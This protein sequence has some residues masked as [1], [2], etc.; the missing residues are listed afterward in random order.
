MAEQK[1]WER[2]LRYE[3]YI[4]SLE[5]NKG[6]PSDHMLQ[7]LEAAGFAVAEG[8]P[9][10]PPDLKL[11]VESYQQAQAE[12]PTHW[13]GLNFSFPMGSTETDGTKAIDMVFAVMDTLAGQTFDPQLGRMVGRRQFEAVADS[14]RRSYAFQMGIAGAVDLGSGGP[15][16]NI[17]D[18]ENSFFSRHKSI[19]LAAFVIFLGILVFKS[20]FSNWLDKAMVAPPPV[21]GPV[22]EP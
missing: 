17:S 12:D 4:R 18:D 1:A 22:Q 8:L 7:V 21:A 14:W 15:M 16:L 10:Q 5:E 2:G 9:C 19:L 20:C 3:L 11:K 6:W 13:Q